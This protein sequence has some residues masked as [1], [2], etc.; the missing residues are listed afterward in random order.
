MKPTTFRYPSPS[1]TLPA[2]ILPARA[3]T[4]PMLGVP[5]DYVV[6][7]GRTVIVLVDQ[8]QVELD[9]HLIANAPLKP[10]DAVEA[11]WRGQWQPAIVR[12]VE[13]STVG[14]AG[15][16]YWYTVSLRRKNGGWRDATV[17]VFADVRPA[18]AHST[19]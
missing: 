5:G 18:E 1:S 11:R 7:K 8:A 6:A 19:T 3:D 13:V 12:V 2:T 10:G 16:R 4:Q 9:R 15:T 17:R 14:K